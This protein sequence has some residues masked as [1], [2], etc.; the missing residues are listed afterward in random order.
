MVECLSG[1]SAILHTLAEVHA[2]LGWDNFVEEKISNFFVEVAK[3]GLDCYRSGM[4]PE[5][6]CTTLVSKLLQLSHKQ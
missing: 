2:K 5:R 4:T 1:R 6:W 3:S